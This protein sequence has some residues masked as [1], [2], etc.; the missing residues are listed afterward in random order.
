[1]SGR[2]KGQFF[3][4]GALILCAAFF[5]FLPQ[6]GLFSSSPDTDLTRLSEYL[7]SEITIAFNIAILEDGNPSKL[8]DFTS[9]LKD[10]LG[11]RFLEYNGFIVATIPDPANPGD[12]D[13]QAGNWLGKSITASVTRDINSG[14][15]SVAY[16][17]RRVLC[18]SRVDIPR[19]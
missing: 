4:A 2:L 5:M 1:M 16:I 18:I 14:E 19:E 7:E 10:R 3:I 15:T 6:Q 9:F 13:V 12:M 17:S 8:G 11:D